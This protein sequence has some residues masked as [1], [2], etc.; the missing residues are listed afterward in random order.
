MGISKNHF[1]HIGNGQFS[2][3]T[4][5][6]LDAAFEN[7]AEEAHKNKSLVIHFHGG[8][9]SRKKAEA[10]IEGTDE[11]G[12]GLMEIFDTPN[13][14]PF[15]VLWDSGVIDLLRNNFE[16][17]SKEELFKKIVG[18]VI[19]FVQAKMGQGEGEKGEYLELGSMRDISKELRKTDAGEVPFS[20]LEAKA[21]EVSDLAEVE[22][23]Q[24]EESLEADAALKMEFEKVA[25][26]LLTDENINHTELAEKGRLVTADGTLLSPEKVLEIRDDKGEEGEKGLITSAK[27][28]KAAVVVLKNVVA[29]FI[30]KTHHGVYTTVVEEVMREFYVANAGKFVWNMMKKDVDDAFGDD[31]KAFGGTA[32]MAAIKKMRETGDQRRII[33]V[34]HNSGANF[35]AQMLKKAD[36][37]ELPEDVQF[38]VIFLGASMTMKDFAEILKVHK[39]RIANF[40]QFGLGDFAESNDKALSY[41]Y[42][43]S[44]LYLIS[45]LLEDKAD[46]PL[47]GMER[48][49]RGTDPYMRSKNESLKVVGDFT[50]A[51]ENSLIWSTAD[52]GDGLN[53]DANAHDELYA[54]ET[55]LQSV[56]HLV[57]KGF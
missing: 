52:G 19:Q 8:L 35:V 13:S 20:E 53:T 44:V 25:R 41:L 10:R 7:L 29:R 30:G 12:P 17:I 18:R 36:E 46:E 56:R 24:F 11:K 47:V 27:L 31:E 54:G 50:D 43:R 55:T 5:K 38:D 28:I 2:G 15:F 49:Y 6:D 9:V 37:L 57:E 33:L 21:D 1:L 14:Y 26:N 48:Y 39:N 42:P 22:L 45:G 40:R 3:T 51:V 34:G 4:Y 16:E 32:L 23:K